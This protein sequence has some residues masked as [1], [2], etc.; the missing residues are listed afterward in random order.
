M[1]LPAHVSLGVLRNYAQRPI[2]AILKGSNDG[3]LLPSGP[4][5]D[6]RVPPINEFTF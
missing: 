2:E 4:R 3:A 1:Q 5:S 6:G